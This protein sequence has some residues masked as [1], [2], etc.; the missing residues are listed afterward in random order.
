MNTLFLVAEFPKLS[1]TF[2]LNQIRALEKRG[3]K[4]FL[5][6]LGN[7]DEEKTHPDAERLRS[8]FVYPPRWA[9]KFLKGLY[10]AWNVRNREIDIIH[11]HFGFAG[12]VA[13]I[14]RCI[15]KIPLVT[16]FYGIDASPR[17]F[18]TK[19]YRILFREGD[20][21]LV[22]SE[23]MK[24]DLLRLGCP[25][26][27]I[28]IQHVGVDLD[29]IVGSRL[30]AQGSKPSSKRKTILSVGRLVEKK[31]FDDLIKAVSELRIANCRLRIIGSG[32][33]E[34]ELRSLVNELGL[35]DRVKFLGPQ[36]YEV[37]LEEL[38]KADVFVLASHTAANG[39]K[40]GTPVVLMDA[41]AA[42]VPV[43]STKHAGIPEV[44][45]DSRSG[46]LVEER[47][48]KALT[49]AIENILGNPELARQMGREGRRY[50]EKEYNIAK[51]AEK[52]EQVYQSLTTSKEL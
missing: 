48:I 17:R 38:S 45:L 51:Q 43:V 42:G 8:R 13:L 33:L 39:D 14:V 41:Q 21:F 34:D 22:L 30:K 12:Q 37:V 9:K 49:R 20:L 25:K 15:L 10:F 27:K 44:V 16:S 3:H 7:P 19:D 46:I 4:L 1:E 31:G 18:S 40:E 36:P 47:D 5:C 50:V 6:A 52:L 28:R 26:D 11:A 24:K 32:P 2:I 29:V 23:D 35:S